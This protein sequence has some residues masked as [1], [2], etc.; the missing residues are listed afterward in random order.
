MATFPQTT[1]GGISLSRLICGTNWFLGYSH[2]SHAKDK[3]IRDLFDTPDKIGKVI[4]TFARRGVNAV[5][6]P[7]NDKI[8]VAVKEAS[9]RVGTKIHFICTPDFAGT[10]SGAPQDVANWPAV[11]EKAKAAG[12]TF[13]FPH[14]CVTDSRIDRVNRALAPDLLKALK[15]VKDYGLVPGLSTHAPE[16]MVCADACGADCES[17]V[18]PY[19]AIGFLCQVET[20]WIQNVIRNAKKPVMT[21][22]PLAAGRI[23]PPTGFSFVWNTIRECDMVTIGTMSTYEAE[24]AVEL[25]LACIE[26]RK[27]EIQLQATRSKKVLQTA[28]AT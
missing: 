19:N 9:Q 18:Q 5:M 23:L 6:G 27:A 28:A 22:K 20:D 15:I 26:Q 1:V 8:A 2:T 3:L 13:C 21:I 25:S 4:E 10:L 14:Q 12:A 16:A 7:L 17:Y 11:V 24:E